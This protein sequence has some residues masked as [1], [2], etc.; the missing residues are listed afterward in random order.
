MLCC[1]D[2]SHRTRS[3]DDRNRGGPQN[4]LLDRPSLGCSD[5]D[6]KRQNNEGHH[7]EDRQAQEPKHGGKDT[8]PAPIAADLRRSTSSSK[9]RSAIYGVSRVGCTQASLGGVSVGD[10]KRA[11][12]AENLARMWHGLARPARHDDVVSGLNI[13]APGDEI[14]GPDATVPTVATDDP[15]LAL[16]SRG[17]FTSI[18][19]VKPDKLTTNGRSTLTSGLQAGREQLHTVR[20]VAHRQLMSLV[21]TAERPVPLAEGMG[22]RISAG[23]REQPRSN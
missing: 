14:R 21:G 13:D 4:Y 8:R 6:H 18:V 3:D 5:C 16:R 19:Q 15:N 7:H 2:P 12:V 17:E 10:R 23:Q 1:S 11:G 20:V 9:G 22:W